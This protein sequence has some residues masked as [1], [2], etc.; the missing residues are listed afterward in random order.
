MTW[1][2]DILADGEVIYLTFT[3]G[4][5]MRVYSLFDRK[6]KE[7]L[8]LVLASTDEAVR[9]AVME[10]IP[11]SNSTVAKYPS[12]FDVMYLGDFDPEDG[13]LRGCVKPLLIASVADIIAPKDGV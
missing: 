12:D 2:S 9:R 13:S 6:V 4:K 1:V 3:Q 11:G 10:G 7:Y 5:R 8:S